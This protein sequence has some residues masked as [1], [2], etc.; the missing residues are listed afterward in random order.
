MTLAWGERDMWLAA[1]AALVAAASLTA[2]FTV[3][4]L[5]DDGAATP[6]VASVKQS[7]G[8]VKLRLAATLGWKNVVRGVDV[9][10]GDALFVPPGAEAT[11]AFADGTELALDERTLVVVER[12]RAGPRTVTLRQGSVSGRA[13]SEGLTLA[14][15]AG[16]ARLEAAAEAHVE[17]TERNEL[18]VAVKKGAAKVKGQGAETRVASGQRVAAAETG[19][20][21]LAPWPVLLGA[22]E[23]QARLPFRGT[24]PPVT[25]SWSGT[26]PAGARVQVARDRLFAFVEQELAATETSVVLPAPASGITWWRVVDASGR[27]VSEARRFTCSEDVSPVAMFPRNGEVLLAPPGTEVAFAWTPL[28]GITRYRLELSSNQGFEPVARAEVVSGA[29]ARLRLDLNE[30]AWFWRVRVDDEGGAG[31]PSEGRRFRVIHKGIPDAPE[32]LTPEIE[33]TP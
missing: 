10:D 18:E 32:L 28:P 31:V 25:L 3:G 26:V 30:G 23:A 24:P 9:H 2:A 21:A 17:L 13:G 6:T 7:S 11:L 12:P 16:E 5:R 29:T 8:Q 4:T 19:T 27:P 20:T 22:P 14:T 15:A 1:L 33:V